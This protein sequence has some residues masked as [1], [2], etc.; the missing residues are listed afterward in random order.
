MDAIKY[1]ILEDGTITIETDAVS[2]KNH[3]SAD[4]MLK[5]LS[6][7]IGGPTDIKRKEGH[8]YSHSHGKA[9]HHHKH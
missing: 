5:Q 6:A 9:G 7:V 4:E 2:G 3:Q 1:E 8:A